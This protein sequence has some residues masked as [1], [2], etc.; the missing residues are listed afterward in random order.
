LHDGYKKE[1][2]N[3]AI[4]L[5]SEIYYNLSPISNYPKET[6]L[7]LPGMTH[8]NL[9]L[10]DKQMST[11][12]SAKTRQFTTKSL[13]EPIM[14]L[15]V[16]RLFQKSGSFVLTVGEKELLSKPDTDAH[17]GNILEKDEA[18]NLDSLYS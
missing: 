6:L 8:Q 1:N 3:D 14:G 17:R 18:V 11:S 5:I 10:Y 12:T 16:S 15:E 4:N 13:L 7:S 9:S 2:H